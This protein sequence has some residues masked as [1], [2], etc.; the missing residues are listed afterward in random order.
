MRKHGSLEAVI[1]NLDTDKYTVPENFRYQEARE[2]FLH[3][4]VTPASELEVHSTTH[5]SIESEMAREMACC[6]TLSIESHCLMRSW[7]G[8]IPMKRVSRPSWSVRSSSASRE[9]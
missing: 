6:L 5:R 3:P 1:E 2:L 4:E 7:Y 8:A 9:S